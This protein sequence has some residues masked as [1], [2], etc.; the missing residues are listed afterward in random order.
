MSRLLFFALV[1]FVVYWLLKSYRRQVSRDEE[2]PPP[3]VEDMVRC[4]QC[5]VH[6]PRG[7]SLLTEGRYFC[8]AEHRRL[9]AESQKK[10]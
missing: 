1:A 8:S 5:G 3:V 10:A 9:F 6:L 7:E 2:S 4:A